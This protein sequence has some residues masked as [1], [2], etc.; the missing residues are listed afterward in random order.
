MKMIQMLMVLALM[1]S[2]MGC[3]CSETVEAGN[4]A[5]ATEWGQTQPNTYSEGFHW[6]SPWLDL[7]PMSTRTQTYSMGGVVR[8][9]A[10][11]EI[12]PEPSVEVLTSDQLRVQLAV[13]IQFHLNPNDA[14]AIYRTYGQN[15][16]DTVVHQQVRTAVRDAASEFTAIHLVQQREVLQTRMEELVHASLTRTLE[17]R[18]VPTTAVVIENILLRNIDLPDSLDESIARV[19]QQQQET[20]QRQQAL[21]TAQAEAERLRAEAQGVADA[22]ITTTRGEAEARLISARA[23]AE[24]NEAISRSLTPQIVELR[25][26]DAMT[27]AISGAGSRLVFLPEGQGTT[28]RLQLPQ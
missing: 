27:T 9:G 5:V 15:Y 22:R 8:Q 19:Q 25:R 13:D 6:T 16:A 4:V 20:A 12:A 14:V 18:E 28:L 23:E 2:A 10:D 24:S 1:T 3:A 21:L 26:I 17:A 7:H 11:G